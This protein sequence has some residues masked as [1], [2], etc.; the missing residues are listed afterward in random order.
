[1]Q[2]LGDFKGL[3]DTPTA[4]MRRDK[5]RLKTGQSTGAVEYKTASLHRGNTPPKRGQSAGAVVY[6]DCISALG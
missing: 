4:S 2:F 6:T 5:N 3:K 1:M